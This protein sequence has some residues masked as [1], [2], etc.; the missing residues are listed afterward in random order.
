MRKTLSNSETLTLANFLTWDTS[1]EGREQNGHLSREL[2]YYEQLTRRGLSITTLTWGGKADIEIAG[3]FPEGTAFIPFHAHVPRPDS[4]ILRLLLSPFILWPAR[5][6]LRNCDVL[7]TEQMVGGWCAVLA[8]YIFRKPLVVRTGYE[9]HKFTVLRGKSLPR[10]IFSYLISKL[11]YSSAD[12]IFVTTADDK[13]FVES[14]FGVSPTKINVLPNWTDTG[15]FAPTK[16]ARSKDEVLFVGRLDPQKNLRLLIEAMEG[17]RWNLRVVGDGPH[18]QVLTELAKEKNVEADFLGNIPNDELVRHYQRCTVFA[19]PS[20]FEG[21][22]KS[23]LE[24]MACGCPVIG[25]DVDGIRPTIN[26]GVDGLLVEETTLS[27]RGGLDRLM[28]DPA[29][30]SRL[31]SAAAKR[32]RDKLSL[33]ALLDQEVAYYRGMGK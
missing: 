14:H 21:H 17:S 3:R 19:L 24:A 8:K 29:L 2:P 5:H 30:R 33:P 23:L 1:L 7:R 13:E 18:S 12:M 10:R 32:I 26:D 9:Y 22:P 15:K 20:K 16:S 27:L 6:E 25:T 28:D 31:G 4:R 11:T